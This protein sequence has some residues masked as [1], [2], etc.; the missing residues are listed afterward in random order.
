MKNQF[1]SFGI[2]KI[3]FIRSLNKGVIMKIWG[4]IGMKDLKVLYT[5]FKECGK[6]TMI[7]VIATIIGAILG[8]LAFYN[9]WLG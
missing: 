1:L 5:Y 6:S 7:I 4:E 2:K 8:V 9:E 3:L